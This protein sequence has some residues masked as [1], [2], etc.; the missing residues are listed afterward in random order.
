[1][2]KKAF[3]KLLQKYRE[4]AGYSQ[5]KLAEEIKRSSIFISYMERGEKSPSVDT[6]IQISNALKISA[7]LLIGTHVQNNNT[8][9]LLHFEERMASLPIPIQQKLMDTFESLINIELAY[10]KGCDGG[11]E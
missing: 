7:D 11:S 2:D 10:A 8:S 3:G 9:R 4:E 6:L 5:E 1:M